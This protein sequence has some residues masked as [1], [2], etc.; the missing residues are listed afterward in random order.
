M[1]ALFEEMAG[2][3]NAASQ[4]E[5][6]VLI[7]DANSPD[8]TAE[9]VRAK[10]LQYPNIH[11]LVEKGKSGIGPAYVAGMRYALEILDAEAFVEF[12]GDG[13]HNPR[14]IVR[15]IDTLE[16]GYDQVIGSRYVA[17]GAIPK[18]WAL[19]RKL[20]S[21]FGSLY[22]RILLEL[23]VYDT[24]SGLK[25]TRATIA[26][27]LPLAEDQLLSKQYAYKLQFLYALARAGVRI[28]EIPI[29]FRI[30]EHDISKSA[31]HDIF[32]S[33]RLTL[34]MRWKTLKEWRLLRVLAI[35]GFSFI[36][37]A[38]LFE[39]V[40]IQLHVLPPGIVAALVGLIAI[41]V[42]FSL[43]ERFSFRDKKTKAAPQAQRFWRF[44]VLSLGSVFLQWALVGATS[45]FI[46]NSPFFLRS[47]YIL[48][49]TLGLVVN[50]IGFYFWVWAKSNKDTTEAV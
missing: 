39:I 23:P 36:F 29:V 31:W 26:Q 18:E 4:H 30:R 21:R 33:L 46:S 8:G 27:H 42:N 38:L 5:W 20:L 40:G 7:V 37:Q 3:F 34:F 41:F 2:V 13:Q 14:D 19:Y 47:A 25:A 12:D 15:L 32:E 9:I 1:E 17:G 11:L 28:Q 24:T 10:M 43:H 44:F 48:A 35:G 50:Y 6:Y 22:A 45:Q 16:S 49:V